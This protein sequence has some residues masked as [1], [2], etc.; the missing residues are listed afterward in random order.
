M[1]KR[2]EENAALGA[3]NLTNDI[4]LYGN[5]DDALYQTIAFGRT[6]I[7]PA[8]DQRLDDVQIRML[9]AWIKKNKS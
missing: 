3:P 1:V 2:E 9:V 8:F 7:M 4:W 6:G 5:S